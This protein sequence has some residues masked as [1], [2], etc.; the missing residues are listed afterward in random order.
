MI[1]EVLEK[2]YDLGLAMLRIEQLNSNVGD[3]LDKQEKYRYFYDIFDNFM[4]LLIDIEYL[5]IFAIIKA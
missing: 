1:T 3:N 2:R 4:I 5:S